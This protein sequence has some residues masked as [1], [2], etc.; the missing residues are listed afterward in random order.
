MPTASVAFAISLSIAGT[1]LLAPCAIADNTTAST[2]TKKVE[3]LPAP[4]VM[5]QCQCVG[6]VYGGTVSTQITGQNLAN[7]QACSAKYTPPNQGALQLA[8]VTYKGQTQYCQP[9]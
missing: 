4:K 6:P 7:N 8:P 1:I 3:K 9:K 2:I 5:M